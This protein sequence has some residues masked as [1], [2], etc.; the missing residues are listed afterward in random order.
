MAGDCC[1]ALRRLLSREFRAIRLRS[2]SQVI[3][4]GARLVR[5]CQHERSSPEGGLTTL[6]WVRQA[7]ADR[8]LFASATLH[9]ARSLARN[10]IPIRIITSIT[11][12]WRRTGCAFSAPSLHLLCIFS[13]PSLHLVCTFSEPSLHLLCIFSAPAL[14]LLC[15]YSAPTLPSARVRIAPRNDPDDQVA[16]GICTSRSHPHP[17]IFSNSALF[18]LLV[19]SL[20]LA[21]RKASTC[22]LPGRSCK[23]ETDLQFICGRGSKSRKNSFPFVRPSCNWTAFAALGDYFRHFL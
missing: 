17:G 11:L 14:H 3:R 2:G 15:T 20:I 22:A 18:F 4:A 19:C 9:L 21:S 12:D 10:S 13:P 23:R 5:T 1:R 8:R 7:E 16:S 6:A